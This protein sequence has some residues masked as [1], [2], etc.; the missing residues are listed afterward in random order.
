MILREDEFSFEGGHYLAHHWIL[1]LDV[2]GVDSSLL[3]LIDAHG[4]FDYVF[5]RAVLDPRGGEDVTGALVVTLV[6]AFLLVAGV[7]VTGAILSIPVLV[8]FDWIDVIIGIDG[9]E[10]LQFLAWLDPGSLVVHVIITTDQSAQ[11]I[12]SS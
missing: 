2:L 6:D 3:G 1:V 7:A 9:T 8:F 12:T 11:F 4:S 5:G 10:S